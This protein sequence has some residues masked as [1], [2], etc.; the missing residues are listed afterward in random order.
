MYDEGRRL[1]GGAQ[2]CHWVGRL[3]TMRPGPPPR[4]RIPRH[5]YASSWSLLDDFT[6]RKQEG[7]IQA[8]HAIQ[9]V[10]IQHRHGTFAGR[11]EPAV[12]ILQNKVWSHR[13]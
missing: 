3:P 13:E 12:R 9:R 7:E 11:S 10:V 5:L 2:R 8:L 4:L 6:C 1:M